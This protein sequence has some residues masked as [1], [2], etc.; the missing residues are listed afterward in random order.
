MVIWYFQ[1]TSYLTELCVFRWL[2]TNK[3]I[4]WCLP[5]R[6]WISLAFNPGHLSGIPESDHPKKWF[7]TDRLLVLDDLMTEGGKDKEL[8]DLFNI[9]RVVLVPWRVPPGK[10]AN[11]RNAAH[12]IIAFKNPRDQLSMRNLL[13]Q[14]FPTWGKDMMD[15]YQKVTKR[16]LGYMVLVLHPVS[17]DRKHVFSQ[18]MTHEGYQFNRLG[19]F[20]AH[21]LG[22]SWWESWMIV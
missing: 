8:L 21:C 2:S 15:I 20:E 13:L 12:H 14:A 6:I 7:P 22:W 5:R 3:D 18:L 17:N 4:L 11:S 9:P 16:S 19:S 10:Y 1:I